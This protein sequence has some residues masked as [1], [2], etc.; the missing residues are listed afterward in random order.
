MDKVQKE[1]QSLKNESKRCLKTWSINRKR[2][3]SVYRRLTWLFGRELYRKYYRMF[4]IHSFLAVSV[5][6]LCVEKIGLIFKDMRMR[7]RTERV[8]K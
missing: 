2:C 1:Q 3:T 8:R 6:L 4:C 7:W 5:Q